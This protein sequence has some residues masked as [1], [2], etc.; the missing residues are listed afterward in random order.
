MKVNFKKTFLKKLKKLKDQK[1][2]DRIAE[3]IADVEA[4]KKL[5]EVINLKKLE[6]FWQEIYNERNELVE[7]HEKFPEDKGH[8]KI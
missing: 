7:I 5:S 8:K 1:L 6:G 2:K 4:A 3:A